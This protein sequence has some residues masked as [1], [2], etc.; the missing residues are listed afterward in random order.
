MKGIHI[1]LAVLLSSSVACVV[2]DGGTGTIDLHE[3]ESTVGQILERNHYT[4]RKLDSD[5]A[6]EILETYLERLDYNKLF[7]TQED[8]DL[9]RNEYRSGLGDDILLGNLTSAKAIY[10]MFKQRVDQ[11]VPKINELLKRQYNFSSN[12]NVTV[13]RKKEPWLA[14]LSEADRIWR[15]WI[16]EELLE[17][18]LSKSRAEPGPEVLGREYSELQ[19]QTDQQDDEEVLR[20]FLEAVAQTY[21]PHSEYLG[22]SEL[23]EFK[24]DTQI[25]ISGIGVQIRVEKGYATIGRIF[26]GG[27]AACSGKLHIG[28][29]IV[30]VAEGDRPFVN[31]V[32]T[33][34]DK[35]TEMVLGKDGSV[36]HLRLI[37]GHGKNPSKLRTVQ[38]LG[39]IT[40]PSFYGEPDNSIKATSVTRDVTMLL[41]RL[42]REGIQGVV[43]DLRN[44]GGG[45]VDEA[46]KMIGLFIN[47]GP[48]AQLKD[49]D[50]AIYVVRG[51]PGKAFYHGPMVVLDNKWTASA[52]EIFSAAMQDYGRAVIVGDSC[53]F[54]KG[55]VQ[56]L[57]ELGTDRLDDTA[58]PAGALKIT[59]EKVYR[60]NGESTQL[61]GVISDITIP[62]LSDSEEF[63]ESEQEH[64]LAYDEVTPAAARGHKP[65][66]LDEL[67]SRSTKRI[68]EDP[69][70]RDLSAENQLITQKLR[71][72]CVSLNEEVRRNEIAEEVHLRDKGDADRISANEH[73]R[74]KSYR[75]ILAEV[76]KPELNQINSKA[77]LVTIRKG[78]IPD[79]TEQTLTSLLPGESDFAT[80]TENDAVTRETLNILSDVL[81]LNRI[82]LMATPAKAL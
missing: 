22:P 3:M 28:D 81:N 46:V 61:K 34:R 51:R 5:M 14:N 71:N 45:S 31:T 64:P 60:V 75:L 63:G 44:N 15:D 73:D 66:F 21:D 26:P 39:W 41:K 1:V 20:R 40:V 18:K 8:I 2:A 38:K 55:T 48:I 9:I 13:N 72:N 67:R 62:S 50:G 36:V 74:T 16:E 59:V 23:N 43:L 58:N 65:L 78:V 82:S 76:V 12:R 79:E 68:N 17:E 7:F 35:L 29:L 37:S 19:N 77:E 54:G 53:S 57:I 10:A 32:Q 27:P 33:E 24:I 47:P 80:G 11:R 25:T 69:V 52:S 42:E 56:T 70:F 4:Q 30:G 6:K 49:S